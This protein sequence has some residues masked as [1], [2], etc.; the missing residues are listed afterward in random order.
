V[1]V[2]NIQKRPKE[3]LNI[4]SNLVDNHRY[5]EILRDELIEADFLES[6]PQF[7]VSEK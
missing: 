5:S 6:C 3:V 2:E 1:L 4:I 7:L